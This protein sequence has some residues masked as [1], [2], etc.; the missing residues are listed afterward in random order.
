MLNRNP[1][2][3]KTMTYHKSSAYHHHISLLD[4]AKQSTFANVI[5]ISNTSK[6]VAEKAIVLLHLNQNIFPED[7]KITDCKAKVDA[8][9][10]PN[11][12]IQLNF[13]QLNLSPGETT[14][15][16]Y[17]LNLSKTEIDKA[18]LVKKTYLFF[19]Q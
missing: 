11:G 8:Q 2:S 19:F 16:T 7:F 1:Y 3:S 6:F 15:C 13:D 5:D 18:E 14:Q 12:I 17:R 4:Q 10:Y 9:V